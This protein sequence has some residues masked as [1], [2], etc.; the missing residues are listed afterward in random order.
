MLFRIK[1]YFQIPFTIADG[2]DGS[3]LFYKVTLLS[4]DKE[5]ASLETIDASTCR[6]DMIINCSTQVSSSACPR[7]ADITVDIAGVSVLGEGTANRR[8]VGMY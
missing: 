4:S 6:S 3:S 2:I 7:S 1:H 5:C 8:V